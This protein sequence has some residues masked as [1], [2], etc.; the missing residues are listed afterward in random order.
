[1]IVQEASS[2]IRTIKAQRWLRII[3]VALIMY[4]IS[5]IDR[6]N[7]SLALDP[8]ISTMMK[9][10]L[11]DDRLKGQ[12]AGI[13]FFGYV[14]LQIPGG[15]LAN[16]WSA[17]K[18]IAIFLVM[19]GAAAVGCGMVS[20][21]GQFQAMRFLLGVAE[22]GVFPATLVLLANWFPRSERARANAYWILCQPLA[23]GIFAPLTGW[24]IGA[25][26]WKQMII[27]EGVLPFIWLP[28]WLYFISDHPREA[29]WISQ[30]ERA[31][32]EETLKRE[33]AELSPVKPV[34]IW[35]AFLQPTVFVMLAIYFLQNCAAYGCMTFFTEGLKGEGRTASGLQY[36]LLFAIPYILSAVCM[37][38]NSRHSD[39]THER[40]KH[41]ALPYAISGVCLIASVFVKEHSFWASYILLCLAIP[42]PFTSQAPFWAIPSETLPRNV[43]GSVMGLVNAI[44]NLGG[45]V[46]PFII[47]ALKKQTHGVIIP[48]T[49]IGIG[50][51]VAAGLCFL[52]PVHI[53]AKNLP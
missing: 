53:R 26:G 19:W 11:M 28:V 7:V 27:L 49:V 47:G 29:K 36:G 20:T 23:A 46:G 4:T 17:K 21:F 38:L 48:F 12:A 14:L 42:G 43:L 44:G 50:L 52:L 34:P 9:D 1:M 39:K 22:S 32:L 37:I 13:F 30:E 25:W 10:L 31:Y 24:M 41:V 33:A 3:P 51:I 45:F 35:Q 16:H 6:T 15:Y 2:S 5:Y 8:S 40:R 18:L